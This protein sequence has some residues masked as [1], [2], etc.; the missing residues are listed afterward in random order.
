MRI[1]DFKVW[2]VIL[3]DFRNS[4]QSMT[5]RIDNIS[6]SWAE[7]Y[8]QLQVRISVTAKLYNYIEN[9]ERKRLI[10]ETQSPVSFWTP[11]NERW[12]KFSRIIDIWVFQIQ[13]QSPHIFWLETTAIWKA[14]E[15]GKH[16]NVNLSNVVS[17]GPDRKTLKCYQE[18][19]TRDPHNQLSPTRERKIVHF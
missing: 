11:N 2:Q 4:R 14:R 5:S 9:K 15:N 18:H 7:A 8:I 19:Y 3:R 13:G 6:S 16:F 17:L 12:Y 1:L 10:A